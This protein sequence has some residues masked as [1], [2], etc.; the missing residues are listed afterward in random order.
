MSKNKNLVYTAIKGVVRV[1]GNNYILPK[2]K[3]GHKYF[4]KEEGGAIGNEG[5]IYD[6]KSYVKGSLIAM[7]TNNEEYIREN[8]VKLE[9]KSLKEDVVKT[10]EFSRN[11]KRLSGCMGSDTLRYFLN[12]ILMKSGFMTAIDGNIVRRIVSFDFKCNNEDYFKEGYSIPR[13]AVPN[14][15]K[16][17][18]YIKEPTVKIEYYNATTGSNANYICI[19]EVFFIQLLTGHFPEV[20]KLYK[21]AYEYRWYHFSDED[22]KKIR[23]F[24]K[25]Y[26]IINDNVV[27]SRGD[28]NTLFIEVKNKNESRGLWL[29]TYWN[30]EPIRVNMEYLL[31]G[32]ENEVNDVGVISQLDALC[33]NRDTLVM[34]MRGDY[35]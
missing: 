27:L 15:I 1:E 16:Y 19:N 33:F 14:L 5:T 35:Y 25:D 28:N 17:L 11:L 18:D 7:S 8:I 30:E 24:C 9:K 26:K 32:L 20:N 3:Y 23:E 31:L 13:D 21:E 2:I 34:P 6:Y 10:K 29:D 22:T 12:G 4:I